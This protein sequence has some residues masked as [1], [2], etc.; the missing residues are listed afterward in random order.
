MS[1]R[2]LNLVAR[3][4]SCRVFS[5]RLTFTIRPLPSTSSLV[6]PFALHP[7]HVP[8]RHY[9]KAKNAKAKSKG[10]SAKSADDSAAADVE[11]PEFDTAKFNDKM[12][13]GIDGLKRELANL[14][15]GRANPALL[16][17]VQV[18]HKGARLPLSQVAQVT[19]KDPQTL[20]VVV[21]DEELTSVI[22]RSIRNADLNLNPIK[23]NANA[24]KVPIPRANKEIKDSLR[25]SVTKF[26]EKTR[27]H[28]RSVR[29]DARKEL[30]KWQKG[31]SEDVSRKLDQAI[32]AMTDKFIKEV[33]TVVAAKNKEIESA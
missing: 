28:V 29:G 13:R 3:V 15:V 33:D 12:Q 4:C 14:R 2:A 1:L 17:A 27:E 11:P 9:A 5:P 23:E 16:D 19:I 30:Q 25:K 7:N 32:Q 18:E 10:G 6:Q 26:A 8:S 31:V 20:I 24:L 21:N 22:E